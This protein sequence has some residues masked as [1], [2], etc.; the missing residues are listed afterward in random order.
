[1]L[2]EN[3]VKI[4][5]FRRYL[6]KYTVRENLEDAYTIKR[7]LGRGGF[8]TVYLA[9]DKINNKLRAVKITKINAKLK[10]SNYIDLIKNEVNVL[11]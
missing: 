4:E 11:R 1:M 9:R 7:E 3:T 6:C 10:Q 8:S 2:C 5:K